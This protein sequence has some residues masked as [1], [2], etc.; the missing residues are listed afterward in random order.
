MCNTCKTDVCGCC[1]QDLPSAPITCEATLTLKPWGA[2]TLG[3]TFYAKGPPVRYRTRSRLFVLG[4]L[5]A[6]YVI[7]RQR[8]DATESEFLVRCSTRARVRDQVFYTEH[9]AIKYLK[10][11]VEGLE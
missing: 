8:P 9:D 3:G 6:A 5:Y 7:Q 1:G 4:S 2:W 11:L 10:L